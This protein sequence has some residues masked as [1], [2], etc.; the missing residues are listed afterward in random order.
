MTRNNSAAFHFAAKAASFTG[1]ECLIWPHS[2]NHNGYGTVCVDGKRVLAHRYILRLAKGD[3]SSEDMVACHAPLVC[4]NRKCVAPN[5]LRW[6]TRA[7]NNQDQ[8]VDGVSLKGERNAKAKLTAA[9]VI[10]MRLSGKRPSE[11]AKIYG[12]KIN[13]VCQILSRKRWRH[14]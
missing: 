14:V 8:I 10:E 6:A 11:L 9:Q 2:I 7:E 12:V 3:P 4:H 1:D 13:T 5:H